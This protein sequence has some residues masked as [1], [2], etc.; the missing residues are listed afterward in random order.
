MVTN[1]ALQ[2][3]CMPRAA[4]NVSVIFG[5]N[6]QHM[7]AELVTSAVFLIQPKQVCKRPNAILASIVTKLATPNAP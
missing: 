5:K 6:K 3:R 1:Q 7:K 4:D 2:E